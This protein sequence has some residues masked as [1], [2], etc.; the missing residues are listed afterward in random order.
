VRERWP[1]GE[2]LADRKA[3]GAMRM[4]PDRPRRRQRHT[5][6]YLANGRR[7]DGNWTGLFAPGERVRLRFVNGAAMTFFDVRIPGLKITVVAADGQDMHP[8]DGR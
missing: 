2:H 4:T 6:T 1:E 7:A 5:Y 8:V 3:W